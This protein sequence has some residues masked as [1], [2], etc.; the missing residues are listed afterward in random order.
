MTDDELR[1]EFLKRH[2]NETR[3]MVTDALVKGLDQRIAKLSQI[4]KEAAGKPNIDPSEH[5]AL[6]NAPWKI[7]SGWGNLRDHMKLLRDRDL[8]E[9]EFL[10]ENIRDLML[11]L[12]DGVGKG[13]TSRSA[14]KYHQGRPRALGR[15]RRAEKDKPRVELI[16]GAVLKAAQEVKPNA[17]A[18]SMKNLAESL[19]PSV[20]QL[21]KGTGIEAG[22][23]AIRTRLEQ[24]IEKQ[25]LSRSALIE[26]PPN[27]ST[28]D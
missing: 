17:K 16:T 27:S 5:H 18:S 28:A 11:G 8:D 3:M 13:T 26:R 20:K 24:L 9:Y 22:P 12:I 4:I 23:K 15:T 1:E 2:R 10:A 21:L 6:S 25:T 19:Y 7:I 14:L